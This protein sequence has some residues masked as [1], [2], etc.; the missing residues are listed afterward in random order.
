M[1]CQVLFSGE[2][3]KKEYFKMSSAEIFT[4]HAMC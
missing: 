3:K 2:K 1:K 4:H